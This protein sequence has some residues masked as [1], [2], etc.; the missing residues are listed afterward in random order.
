MNYIATSFV[1]Y[2]IALQI[3]RAILKKYRKG[4]KLCKLFLD[5][6]MSNF[7]EKF[8]SYRLNSMATIEKTKT[9]TYITHIQ[10]SNQA[11]T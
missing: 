5:S 7:I 10:T 9:H 6:H 3:Y 4:Q 11:N 1:F 8:Q 2:G